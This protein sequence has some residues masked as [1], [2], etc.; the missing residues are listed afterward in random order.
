MSSTAAAPLTKARPWPLTRAARTD[1][2]D[3]IARVRQELTSMTGQGIEEGVFRLPVSMAVRRLDALMEVLE[4]CQVVD[5]TD[6]VAIGRHATLRD[7]DGEPMSCLVAL[8]GDGDPANGR[9]SA[10]SPLGAAILGARP[11]DAV[12]VA[13]PAGSWSVTVVAVR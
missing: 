2:V 13:A 9:I 6:C 3:E 12:E 8:P 1:L 5:D 11:G 10:D 7:A 4:R